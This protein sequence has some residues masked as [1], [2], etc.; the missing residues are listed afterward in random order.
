MEDKLQ[1][2]NNVNDAY[3]IIIHRVLDDTIFKSMVY[4]DNEAEIEEIL[5]R[6]HDGELY[7]VVII[8]TQKHDLANIRI[9]SL[10]YVY[11]PEDNNISMLLAQVNNDNYINDDYIEVTLDHPEQLVSASL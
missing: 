7:D 9:R 8:S 1:Y 3:F 10:N 4:D 5:S 2:I 11:V 6:C